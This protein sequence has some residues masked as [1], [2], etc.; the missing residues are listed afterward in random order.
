M[1]LKTKVQLDGLPSLRPGVF[2]CFLAQRV[3]WIP[4]HRFRA[5]TSRRF[6]GGSISRH[7]SSG[8]QSEIEFFYMP[9]VSYRLLQFDFHNDGD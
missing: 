7:P 2:L 6:F 1:S 5:Q 9:W 4:P 3:V 8:F